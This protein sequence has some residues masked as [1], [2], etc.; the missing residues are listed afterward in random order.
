MYAKG[1]IEK[2]DRQPSFRSIYVYIIITT[3]AAAA[4]AADSN[5]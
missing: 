5:I 2:R 1:V 3:T 4:A